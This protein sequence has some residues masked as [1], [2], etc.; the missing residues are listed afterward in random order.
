M[1]KFFK[2]VFLIICF[3][4]VFLSSCI[5]SQAQITQ[6]D[7]GV[8][9]VYLNNNGGNLSNF[10]AAST[11]ILK[12]VDANIKGWFMQFSFGSYTGSNIT[13]TIKPVASLDGV[14]YFIIPR[15]VDWIDQYT[16]VFIRGAAN[17][18]QYTYTAP[19]DSSFTISQSQTNTT[20]YRYGSSFPYNYI[21]FIIS[22]TGAGA[23]C[24]FS[25]TFGYNKEPNIVRGSKIMYLDT[26]NINK[27]TGSDTVIMHYVPANIKKWSMAIM[28]G[29]PIGTHAFYVTPIVSNTGIN[30]Y[31]SIPRFKYII[32]NSIDSTTV[33]NAITD[34]TISVVG[35]SIQNWKVWQGDYMP[36]KYVGI[37][38]RKTANA[39]LSCPV[40][41]IFNY[42]Y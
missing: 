37:H 18:Y 12:P 40:R 6:G 8:N 32:S 9:Y 2:P 13:F 14:H 16:K 3:I 4:T 7:F 11:T 41:V 33:V 28:N 17:N 31:I 26:L 24:P 36:V 1:K 29:Q 39:A 35:S 10:T 34:T 42:N 19:F 22:K 27:T 5:N 30:N 15:Q 38:I 20:V 21:G 25:V 23:I